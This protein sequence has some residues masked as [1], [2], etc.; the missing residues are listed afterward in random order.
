VSALKEVLQEGKYLFVIVFTKQAFLSF[1][2]E[3]KTTYCPFVLV[4]VKNIK[5][6]IFEIGGRIDLSSC[7]N[8]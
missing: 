3:A 2:Q 5:T 7:S 1:W 8:I 6:F 4:N